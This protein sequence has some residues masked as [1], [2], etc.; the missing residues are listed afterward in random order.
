MLLVRI[1]K[2][3]RAQNITKIDYKLG[4]MSIFNSVVLLGIVY[5][6]LAFNFVG[7]WFFIH[8]PVNVSDIY[9]YIFT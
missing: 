6:F 5:P 9:I 1:N 7:P 2:Q 4:R 3:I 8:L